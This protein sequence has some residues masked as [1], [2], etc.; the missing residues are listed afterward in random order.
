MNPSFDYCSTV[1]DGIS[2]QLSDKLHKLQNRAARFIKKSIY[3]TSSTVLLVK[4]DWEQL[5]LRRKKQK[6]LTVFKAIHKLTPGYLHDLFFPR[7]TEYFLRDHEN[8]LYLARPPTEF[9]KRSFSYRS[10]LLWNDLPKEMRIL[11]T[12]SS[13]RKRCTNTFKLDS[14][15]T[16]MKTQLGV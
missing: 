14:H 4:L 6:A 5:Q 12:L 2:K 3:Y 7:S 10:A 11:N 15:T 16:I 13:L 8:K 1:W 9:L